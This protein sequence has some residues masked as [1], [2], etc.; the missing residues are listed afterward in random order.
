M[1]NDSKSAAMEES[2]AGCFPRWINVNV[3]M[4]LYLESVFLFLAHLI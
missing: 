3:G 1:L 4:F 2:L